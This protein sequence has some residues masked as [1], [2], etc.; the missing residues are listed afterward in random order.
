MPFLSIKQSKSKLSATKPAASEANVVCNLWDGRRGRVRA[1]CTSP[2]LLVCWSCLQ[3]VL[4]QKNSKKGSL[5]RSAVNLIELNYGKTALTPLSLFSCFCRLGTESNRN[6]Q[7]EGRYTN[8]DLTP[9]NPTV[10]IF[11]VAPVFDFRLFSLNLL[12]LRKCSRRDSATTHNQASISCSFEAQGRHYM[13]RWSHAVPLLARV[14]PASFQNCISILFESLGL[15]IESVET[16]WSGAY[17]KDAVVETCRQGGAH[18]PKVVLER[19][20]LLLC[21]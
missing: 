5:G 8:Q 14:M 12:K 18:L 15:E 21:A 11:L 19:T 4:G 1:R 13:P 6:S 16:S 2:W 9:D 17:G 3:E 20:L 7:N 10:P